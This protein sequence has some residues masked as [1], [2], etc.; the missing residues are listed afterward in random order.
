M[1]ALHGRTALDLCFF[2][3]VKLRRD[4][5]QAEQQQP[6]FV[7][8]NKLFHQRRNLCRRRA[9]PNDTPIADDV[10]GCFGERAQHGV[11]QQAAIAFVEIVTQRRAAEQ[12]LYNLFRFA[13]L[14]WRLTK[15]IAA[16]A[17]YVVA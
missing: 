11:Q 2:C 13:L 6:R 10:S 8:H 12:R 3:C 14:F 9:A 5:W 4:V 7:K 1:V 17:V 15:L 16:K